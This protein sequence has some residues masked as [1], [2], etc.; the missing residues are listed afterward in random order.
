[1][2][3]AKKIATLK[4]RLLFN[5]GTDRKTNSSNGNR[6]KNTTRLIWALLREKQYSSVTEQNE[7]PWFLMVLFCGVATDILFLNRKKESRST[8][9]FLLFK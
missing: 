9:K 1:M 7:M 4:R 5:H 8:P 2:T 6:V 3:G